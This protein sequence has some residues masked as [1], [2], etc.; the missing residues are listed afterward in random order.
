MKCIFHFFLIKVIAKTLI[1]DMDETLIHSLKDS[2]AKADYILT[3]PLAT[4]DCQ[5]KVNLRPYVR[6]VLQ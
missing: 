2:D 1:F 6:E 5:I 4:G 3:I